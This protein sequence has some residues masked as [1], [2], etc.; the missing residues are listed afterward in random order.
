MTAKPL[1]TPE[2]VAAR[3]SVEKRTVYGWLK[4]GLLRGAKLGGKVWRIAHDEVDDFV[5]RNQQPTN[6]QAS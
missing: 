5:L 3:C 1:L 6:A 4:K 2:D